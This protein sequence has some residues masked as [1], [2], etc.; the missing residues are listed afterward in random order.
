MQG[1]SPLSLLFLLIHTM[2]IRL[3]KTRFPWSQLPL[4]TLSVA[5]LAGCF[6]LG[7]LSPGY[8]NERIRWTPD[9]DRGNVGSTLSGG[10]RGQTSTACN[11][12]DTATRLDLIVPGDQS[13][14]LTTETNPT[15]AWQVTTQEP[16]SVTFYLADPDL[17]NPLHTETFDI[18]HTT[19]VSVALPKAHGLETDKKYRWTVF[20]TCPGN[21]QAEISARSFVERVEREFL[22]VDNLSALD[23][24]SVYANHGIWYDAIAKLLAAKRQGATDAES[25]VQ[26]LL[27]QGQS[28]ADLAAAMVH[29]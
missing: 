20:L 1:A 8:A 12:S 23:Q 11:T 15:L 4:R 5:L 13:R 27:E 29:R 10:R 25:M 22:D 18:D 3:T 21:S 19:T 26:T 6:S 2:L 24:A 28:Q 14:L 9:S 16:V 17:A 7:V